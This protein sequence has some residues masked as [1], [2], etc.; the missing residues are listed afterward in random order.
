MNRMKR[1]CSHFAA[2]LDNQ[3]KLAARPGFRLKEVI[4]GTVAEVVPEIAAIRSR[5]EKRHDF[6][7]LGPEKLLRT[8]MDAG[9]ELSPPITLSLDSGLRCL[10]LFFDGPAFP[11][12]F[13]F[14]DI[15][16]EDMRVSII[17]KKRVTFKGRAPVLNLSPP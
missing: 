13:A 16:F 10:G 15:P 5:L 9:A 14:D 11:F 7:E 2:S 6:R 17:L 1:Y 12:P 3:G 8:D 4:V